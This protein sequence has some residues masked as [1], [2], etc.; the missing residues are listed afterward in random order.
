MQIFFDRCKTGKGFGYLHK[1]K[2]SL[3]SKKIEN[4]TMNFNRNVKI[5]KKNELAGKVN[6]IKSLKGPTV[7]ISVKPIKKIDDQKNQL[8]IEEKVFSICNKYLGKKQLDLIKTMR[9]GILFTNK[10]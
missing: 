3:N 1:C 7:K 8:K 9:T 4:K 10:L 2:D 5:L 6:T